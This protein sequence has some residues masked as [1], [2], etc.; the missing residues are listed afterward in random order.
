MSLTAHLLHNRPTILPDGSRR[1]HYIEPPVVM[2]KN[3]VTAWRIKSANVE[4]VYKAVA[5]GHQIID[6]IMAATRLSQTTV[7]KALNILN[8]WPDGPRIE[9]TREA[10]IGQHRGRPYLWRVVA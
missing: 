5:D 6:D 9:W 8:T 4:R 10:R 2:T 7:Q 1:A 3:Q